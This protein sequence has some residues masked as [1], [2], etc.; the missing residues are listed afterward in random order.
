M[1]YTPTQIEWFDANDQNQP[2]PKAY[3]NIVYY[4]RNGGELIRGFRLPSGLFY[5]ED[6][7]RVFRHDP[8][9]IFCWAYAPAK[10][11]VS[12]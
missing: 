6:L 1:K 8:T 10:P 5:H 7:G 2:R 9:D 12:K 11:E 3:V 4:L